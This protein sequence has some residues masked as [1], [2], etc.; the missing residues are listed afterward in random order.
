MTIIDAETLARLLLA[1]DDDGPSP[2]EVVEWTE[3]RLRAV[4][5]DEELL[6]AHYKSGDEAI[7]AKAGRSGS[8]CSPTGFRRTRY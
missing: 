1:D 3:D 8:N 6:A 7:L 5:F 4:A 2:K